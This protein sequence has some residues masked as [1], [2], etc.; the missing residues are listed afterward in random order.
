[1]GTTLIAGAIDGQSFTNPLMNLTSFTTPNLND[2]LQ[3]F[4]DSYEDMA[5]NRFE[6]PGEL[7]NLRK[8]WVREP[9]FIP[10]ITVYGLTFLMG[11]IGNIL[12]IFAVLGD[13]KARS[14]TSTFMVSLAAAD[15]L[16]LVVCVPYE[17]ARYVVDHWT[18]GDVLC[19]FSGFVEMLSASA[20]ILNLSAVSVER[21]IVIVLPMKSRTWCTAGNTKKI[22]FLVWSVA[23][24][25]ASPTLY[26]M[27]KGYRSYFKND[28]SIIMHNCADTAFDDTFRLSYAIYRMLVMF[29]LPTL[30][31]VVC[32]SGVIYT[33]WLSSR[34]L[35]KLTSGSSR[36]VHSSTISLERSCLR[37]HLPHSVTLV[38]GSPYRIRKFNARNGVQSHDRSADVLAARKQVIKMLIAIVV[39]FCLCWG[40]KLIYCVL[41]RLNLPMLYHT[42][43][44]TTKIILDCLPYVQSCLNPIIYGFM[45]RNFRRSMMAACRRH[46]CLCRFS[47]CFTMKKVIFTDY[48]LDSKA[49]NG[50]SHTRLTVHNAALDDYHC[51]TP[52]GNSCVS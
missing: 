21:F 18:F 37:Q 11:V 47:K 12:V 46:Y 51:A 39:V 23:I 29:A 52:R 14:V 50:T 16:F 20:S 27:K 30:I 49:S 32:Y 31:M 40:P 15:M 34:Q 7:E 43:A 24:C 25:L 1:M 36:S 10:T 26:V 8:V 45:S 41:L 22:L 4:Y 17:T 28:T 5:Y 48:E 13:R 33:L 9:H 42:E 38:T 2:E 44:F 19:K 35:S 6:Y 3:R